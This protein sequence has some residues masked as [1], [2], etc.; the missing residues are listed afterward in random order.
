[1]LAWTALSVPAGRV[2]RHDD[3]L[4]EGPVGPVAVVAAGAEQDRALGVHRRVAADVGQRP[5]VLDVHPA[6]LGVG[7][8]DRV[9]G[10]AVVIHHRGHELARVA[11]VAGIGAVA[12]HEQPVLQVRLHPGAGSGARREPALGAEVNR[13]HVPVAG[14]GIGRLGVAE[15]EAAQ[16]VDVGA[17]GHHVGALRLAAGRHAV[18]DVVAVADPGLHRD[19]VDEV[20][21]DGHRQRVG[22]RADVGRAV[23]ADRLDA[24]RVVVPALVVDPADRAGG[25]C[26]ERGLGGGVGVTA[27][28]GRPDLL[29]RVV[30]GPRDLVH[31]AEV[32]VVQ[33]ADGAVGRHAGGP[34]AGVDVARPGGG[35]LRR[36]RRAGDAG[37]RGEAERGRS[38]HDGHDLSNARKSDLHQG[39][40][41]QT[42][43]GT[44]RMVNPK[45]RRSM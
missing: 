36:P 8:G 42:G 37:E 26:A 30:R 1:M 2:A 18:G 24:E 25:A 38:G 3:A 41:L 35:G 34:A 23:A 5:A 44:P 11:D 19:P 12:A 33:R 16:V 43:V 29:R 15:V 45:R 27:W 10:G 40:T 21:V 39:S 13:V 6:R 28:P 4:E 7:V 14:V 31:R 9:V 17:A 32:A 20:A 22:D